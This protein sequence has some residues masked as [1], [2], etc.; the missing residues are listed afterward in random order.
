MITTAGNNVIRNYFGM[1][2]GR[3]GGSIALGVGDTTAAPGDTQLSY[4]AVRARVTSVAS[5][6]DNNRIVFRVAVEPG[7]INEIHEVGLFQ[8]QAIQ[9]KNRLISLVGGRSTWTNAT[10]VTD[11]ARV[12]AQTIRVDASASATEVATLSGLSQNFSA[13]LPTDGIAVA[14]Y[15]DANVDSLSVRLG[16]D[17]SNY[18]E[19]TFDNPTPG[20]QILRADLSVATATGTPSW[21]SV[22]YLGISLTATAGGTGSIY[23]DSLTIEDNT[24]PLDNVLVVRDV[25]VTP[26]KTDSSVTTEIELSLGI[27]IS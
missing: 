5:D 26:Q 27:D 13:F 3:I 14:V 2:T 9:S 17:A 1:Q 11:N 7:K 16:S 18:F 23:F 20:Y 8:D 4:E 25:L 10:L 22:T 6:T 21:A 24:S 15:V 12:N 19:F